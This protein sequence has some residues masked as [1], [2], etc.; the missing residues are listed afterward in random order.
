MDVRD[1]AGTM[2]LK[3]IIIDGFK[4]YGSRTDVKGFDREFNAITGEN[5]H[6]KSNFLD[7]I[8]F[9][10][11]ISNLSQVRATN[12]DDLIYKQGL[13]G[14][15]R[16]IVTLVFDNN[17]PGKGPHGYEGLDQITVSRQIAK[18][19]RN[20]YHINGS[21]VQLQRVHNLFHTVQLNVNNP[22]FL[23]MQ[24]RITKVLSMKPLETSGMIAEAAGTKMYENKEANCLKTIAKKDSKL[25]EIDRVMAEDIR[26]RLVKLEAQKTQYS[27]FTK[28][29][30]EKLEAEEVIVAHDY[31]LMSQQAKK[32]H[33][34]KVADEAEKGAIAQR[35]KEADGTTKREGC[36]G[37]KLPMASDGF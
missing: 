15:T 19:G 11:G 26:P 10:L 29:E 21:L 13:S 16:A 8:C 24:G 25:A 36:G 1:E 28:L 20:K 5:G 14:V 7:A 34:D 30:R 6:G 18:G 27:E 4:T 2:H 33:D 32:A 23:I 12:L 37:S 22:N 17:T 9:V 31:F 3:Q 35:L